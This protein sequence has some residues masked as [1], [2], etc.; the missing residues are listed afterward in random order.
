MCFA[1]KCHDF[2]Q[3]VLFFFEYK[4]KEFHI[5][6]KYEGMRPQAAVS[7]LEEGFCR[8]FLFILQQTILEAS[9]LQPLRTTQTL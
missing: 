7:V 6:V 5:F 4:E 9:F 8:F 1:F 3:I 2:S